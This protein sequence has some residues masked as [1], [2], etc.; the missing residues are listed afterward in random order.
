MHSTRYLTTIVGLFFSL[1]GIPG[2]GAV[3][4]DRDIQ[5][6][7]SDHCYACHGPDANQRKAQFRLDQKESAFAERDGIRPIVPGQPDDSELIAR[8]ECPD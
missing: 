7:L 8:I 6:I 4:F 2:Y 3:Q 1:G 5:P